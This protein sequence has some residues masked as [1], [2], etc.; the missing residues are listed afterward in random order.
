MRKCAYIKPLNS[1]LFRNLSE[2]Y[3][4]QTLQKGFEVMK[5]AKIL[6]LEGDW[7]RL[8]EKNYFYRQSWQKYLAKCRRPSKIGQL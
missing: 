4:H 2:F 6:K 7:G 1:K 5:N 8:Q 3:S